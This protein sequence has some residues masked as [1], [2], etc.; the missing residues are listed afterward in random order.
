MKLTALVYIFTSNGADL[1]VL[2]V[3]LATVVEHDIRHI[4][5]KIQC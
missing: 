2:L 1:E 4:C 5:C 3:Y